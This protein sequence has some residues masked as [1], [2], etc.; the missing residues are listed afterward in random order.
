M[1]GERAAR[2]LP[3]PLQLP[4]LS[5]CH[6]SQAGA[7]FASGTCGAELREVKLERQAAGHAGCLAQGDGAGAGPGRTGRSSIES[8]E[9]MHWAL[10]DESD[11][12]GWL[13][14]DDPALIAANDGALQAGTSTDTSIPDRLGTDAVRLPRDRVSTFLR[15]LDARLS[16]SQGQLCGARAGP[17]RCRNPAVR[18]PVRRRRSGLGSTIK[19]LPHLLSAW[20]RAHLASARR[21]QAVMMRQWQPG[22]RAICPNRFFP[23]SRTEV[24]GSDLETPGLG[25]KPARITACQ[26]HGPQPLDCIIIGAGPAGTDRGDLSR[27]FSP[28]DPRHRCRAKPRRDDPAYPQSRW[29]PRRHPWRLTCWRCMREQA[30]R[31]RTSSLTH[32]LVEKIER[33]ARGVSRPCGG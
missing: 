14:R 12:A 17:C 2:G 7:L 28:Q 8:L 23:T 33:T 16:R 18:A 10:G 31:V 21:L 5:L 4:A 24:R 22:R 15:K 9:I 11:P 13:E 6:A 1:G 27:P 25:T 20:L 32:G 29:L 3:S 30:E 19:P 26:N